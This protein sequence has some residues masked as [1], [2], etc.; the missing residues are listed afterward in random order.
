MIAPQCSRDREQLCG[1][2]SGQLTETVAADMT[3][4]LEQCED[5]RR[6]LEL[7]AAGSD[8]W[9][10]AEQYLSDDEL[11]LHESSPDRRLDATS[12]V[13]V[14]VEDLLTGFLDPSDDRTLLGRLDSYDIQGVIGCGGMGIVLKGHDRELNRHVAIKVLAPHYATNGAA[15]KRFR[16]KPRRRQR[17]CTR[18]CWRST[19]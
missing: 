13:V 8:W 10:D 16:A 6:R 1:L 7:L 3:Q 9:R 12:E 2:L 11:D 19:V 5:C 4:H 15:R 18:T 14:S 17:S